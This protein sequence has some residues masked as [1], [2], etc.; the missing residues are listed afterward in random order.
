MIQVFTKVLNNTE[1]GEGSTHDCYVHVST[2]AVN[3][4]SFFDENNMNPHLIDKTTNKT[5][6][7]DIHITKNREF[8]IN[9]LGQYFSEKEARAGDKISFEK[10]VNKEKTQFYVCI[11]KESESVTFLKKSDGYEILNPDRISEPKLNKPYVCNGIFKNEKTKIEIIFKE[12]K[13]IRKDSAKETNLFLI[14]ANG[15]DLTKTYKTNDRLIL[16]NVGG[17]KTLIQAQAWEWIELS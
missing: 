17:V 9:G 13:K 4:N 3:M 7:G 8:R 6:P 10:K 5:V 2:N 11:L 12:A 1:L 14:R 16:K 15:E